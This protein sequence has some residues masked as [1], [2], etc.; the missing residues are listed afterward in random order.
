[1][2]GILTMT[3]IILSWLHANCWLILKALAGL[4]LLMFS[5]TG[6]CPSANIMVKMELKHRIG[7]TQK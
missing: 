3:G 4:N 6:F 1:M 2:A 5:L 7:K